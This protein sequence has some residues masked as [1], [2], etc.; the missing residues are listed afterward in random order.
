[1]KDFKPAMIAYFQ[2]E[3]EVIKRLNLSQL[4]DALNAIYAAWHENIS[5]APSPG[6]IAIPPR[7]VLFNN[8]QFCDRRHREL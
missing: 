3:I 2:K 6:I 1:M 4:D 7:H 5:S 8:L